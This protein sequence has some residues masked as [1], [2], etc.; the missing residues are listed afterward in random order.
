MSNSPIADL[1]YRHYDGPLTGVSK[2]WW[3]IAKMTMQ[4]ATK[5]RGF[6]GWS[7]F[8]AWW[9]FI[10]L[11]IFWFADNVLGNITG[12]ASG[13]N[14]FL[15]QIV[16]KDQFLHG[17]SF[18]QLIL[19]IITLMI[20]VGSIANDNRANALLVYLSKPCSR[21]DYVFGKWLG[22]FILISLVSFVPMMIFWLYGFMSFQQYG[23]WSSAPWLPIKLAAMS[24][25]SGALHASVGL[26]ISSM[27]NQGRLAGATY[28]G[29]YFI[30][31]IFTKVVGGFYV[32]S[33]RRTGQTGSV[34]KQF[35]YASID[36]IQIGLSK[37]FLGTEGSLIL[38]FMAPPPRNGRQLTTAEIIVGSPSAAWILPVFLVVVV[39]GFA[40]AYSR[41]KAVEVVG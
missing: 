33:V 4:V 22:I 23:F 3:S 9:F 5:R 17:Y 18:S 25:C 31:N 10:L 29:I 1:S 26:A 11:A 12:Q 14:L 35:F 37:V 40:I 15:K 30:S 34:L 16:W 41:I 13:A 8:S 27:F 7:L 38:P 39:G 36:G 21:F 32:F 6:W 20:G 19:M 28:A 2:R 24:M